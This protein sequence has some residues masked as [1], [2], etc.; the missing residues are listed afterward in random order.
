M[1]ANIPS[2][3]LITAGIL[4]AAV[5]FFFVMPI[6][7]HHNAKLNAE[8]QAILDKEAEE[9]AQKEKEEKAKSKIVE[10]IEKSFQPKSKKSASNS[11]SFEPSSGKEGP[12]SD[13]SFDSPP[14][15]VDLSE[16]RQN[17]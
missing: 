10:N 5:F 6:F 1:L 12:S 4:G 2:E 14:E 9:K 17:T 16:F 7:M 3:T 8:L 13:P 15:V 11:S